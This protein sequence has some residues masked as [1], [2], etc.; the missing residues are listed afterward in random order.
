MQDKKLSL[1]FFSKQ[2]KMKREGECLHLNGINQ[3]WR[4]G[5]SFDVLARGQ[6]RAKAQHKWSSLCLLTALP[7]HCWCML[8]TKWINC[9]GNCAIDCFLIDL[10]VKV[11]KPE[12]IIFGHLEKKQNS[13]FA[14]DFWF[15]SHAE[16]VSNFWEGLYDVVDL[17]RP[18]THPIGV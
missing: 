6:Y 7:L 10:C 9:K 16:T 14:V 1:T 3:F 13:L 2:T 11:T 17:G 8:A 18:K 4:L 12:L 5:Q 15:L